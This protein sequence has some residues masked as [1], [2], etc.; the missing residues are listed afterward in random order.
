VYLV[1]WPQERYSPAPCLAH[2]GMAMDLVMAIT[3]VTIRPMERTTAGTTPDITVGRS[4]DHLIMGTEAATR[5]ELDT[6]AVLVTTERGTTVERGSLV[7]IAV[8]VAGEALPLIKKRAGLMWINGGSFTSLPNGLPAIS[9]AGC[10]AL[11]AP[12]DGTEKKA[13][14]SPNGGLLFSLQ[15]I[16]AVQSG[17]SVEFWRHERSPVALAS[18]VIE[19]DVKFARPVYNAGH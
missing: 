2:M 16:A 12:Q 6:T 5:A 10:G 8:G 9:P 1:G 11:L 7:G 19:F 17:A 14:I 4:I 13:A 3:G 15:V 18:R